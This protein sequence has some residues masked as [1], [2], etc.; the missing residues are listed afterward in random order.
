MAG[1]GRQR[2]WDFRISRFGTR[3]R[4]RRSRCQEKVKER[5]DAMPE[6]SA[7]QRGMAAM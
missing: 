3:R 6:M 4:G 1:Q 7:G 2:W 5:R